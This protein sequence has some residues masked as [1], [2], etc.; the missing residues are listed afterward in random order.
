MN[1]SNRQMACRL[2]SFVK[3]ASFSPSSSTGRSW[4][5]ETIS[6]CWGWSVQHILLL[7]LFVHFPAAMIFN[8][9]VISLGFWSWS[10]ALPCHSRATLLLTSSPALIIMMRILEQP[11]TSYV[12]SGQLCRLSIWRVGESTHLNRRQK[13]ED[14]PLYPSRT[15]RMSL[16]PDIRLVNCQTL[17]GFCG[18]FALFNLRSSLLPVINSTIS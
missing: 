8:P 13:G 3:S 14:Q 5:A 15:F 1:P 11:I 12:F 7:D 2:V 18:S 4:A 10:F 17:L 16:E 9:I 6:F